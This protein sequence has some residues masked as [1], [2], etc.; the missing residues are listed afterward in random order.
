[1]QV[2]PIARQCEVVRVITALVLARR[3]MFDVEDERM[4]LYESKMA[5]L[6]AITGALAD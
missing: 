1:V 2:A 4:M 3:D 6:A 5:I